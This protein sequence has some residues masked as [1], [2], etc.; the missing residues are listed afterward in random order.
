MANFSRT[1]LDFVFQQILTSEADSA[2]QIGGVFDVLP[3]LVTDP[4][5]PYGMRNVNGSFN[6]L[7]TGQYLFG[8]ADQAFPRLLQPTFQNAGPVTFDVDGPGPVEVGDPTSYT[9][10]S[11]AVFD[12]HPRVISNLIVDQTS[13]NPAAVAAAAQNAGSETSQIGRA[14]V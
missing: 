14:H 12:T 10:F 6:N 1:D 2:Q 8:A 5:L 11:G 4:L 9:Q 13:N 3:T 7:I